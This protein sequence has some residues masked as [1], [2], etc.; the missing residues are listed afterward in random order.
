M[1]KAIGLFVSDPSPATGSVVNLPLTVQLYDAT[2]T[3]LIAPQNYTQ[4]VV[5]TDPDTG[6]STALYTQAVAEFDAAV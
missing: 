4:P 5:I 3:V 1:V 6:T 2:G